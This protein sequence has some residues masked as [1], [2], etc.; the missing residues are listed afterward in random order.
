MM[1]SKRLSEIH[2]SIPIPKL[3]ESCLTVC[4]DQGN[5]Q[6]QTEDVDLQIV[7]LTRL[8]ILLLDKTNRMEFTLYDS[9]GFQNIASHEIQFKKL[10]DVHLEILLKTVLSLFCYYR[11]EWQHT[12]KH[13]E[14]SVIGF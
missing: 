9:V 5:R 13:Q 6:H 14:H 10:F 11:M 12:Q 4:R 2:I 8:F 3:P 7:A 1:N